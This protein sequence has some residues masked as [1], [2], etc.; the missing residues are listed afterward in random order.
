MEFIHILEEPIIL[1]ILRPFT[2]TIYTRVPHDTQISIKVVAFVKLYCKKK[3]KKLVQKSI[4]LK[5]LVL[6]RKNDFEIYFF[7]ISGREINI[8]KFFITKKRLNNTYGLK[9]V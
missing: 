1:H 8:N 9:T 5:F 2:F 4:I 3:T 7:Q 6:E